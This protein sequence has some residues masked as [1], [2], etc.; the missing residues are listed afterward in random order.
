MRA[1]RVAAIVAS[2]ACGAT[3]AVLPSAGCGGSGTTPVCLYEDGA[4]DLE[5]GC[6]VPVEASADSAGDALEDQGAPV[7][8]EDAPTDTNPPSMVDASDGSAD[9][10]AHVV[11]TTEDA[12][13][14][15]DA[16]IEDA[17]ADSKG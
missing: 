9:A 3:A 13:N 11:D 1:H 17:H 2:L 14:V 16:H 15:G 10:D 5:A 6:G 4:I 12:H 8:G 7:T